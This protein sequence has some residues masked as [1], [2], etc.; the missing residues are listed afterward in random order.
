MGVAERESRLETGSAGYLPRKALI[1]W[2]GSLPASAG[3]DKDS[4]QPVDDVD[5][6]NAQ[7]EPE[8][9]SVDIK[10][11]SSM[12]GWSVMADVTGCFDFNDD[13]RQVVGRAGLVHLYCEDVAPGISLCKRWKCG[14]IAEPVKGANFSKS[15]NEFDM[16]GIY[17]FCERCYNQ[18]V[19]ARVGTIRT[20]ST[21][22]SKS[23][24]PSSQS[25][26]REASSSSS[27][28]D[29]DLTISG[30]SQG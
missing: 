18:T 17:G 27:S 13:V 11:F 14:V 26:G 6:V 30:T 28:S 29:F 4:A 15:A 23:S 9:A 19:V 25:A 22:P 1:P 3:E 20:S 21:V 24:S 8:P 5:D 10:R 12:R 16:S 2:N 7:D